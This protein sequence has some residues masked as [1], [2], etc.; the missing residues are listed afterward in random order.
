MMKSFRLLVLAFSVLL[1]WVC[2]VAG[3]T[4]ILNASNPSGAKLTITSPYGELPEYGFLPIVAELTNPGTSKAVWD[5]EQSSYGRGDNFQRHFRLE[6]PPMESRSVALLLATGSVMPNSYYGG[7]NY[8]NISVRS[9]GMG[10]SGNMNSSGSSGSSA[11]GILTGMKHKGNFPPGGWSRVA[12]DVSLASSDWRAYQGFGGVL[13]SDLE[14]RSMNPGQKLALTTWVKNGGALLVAATESGQTAATLG[15]PAND[16]ST[17]ESA[18]GLGYLRVMEAK[19]IAKSASVPFLQH[20]DA[21]R[22]SHQSSGVMD[23]WAAK[24]AMLAERMGRG[25]LTGLMLLVV[26]V[27]AV[28]IGPINLFIIAPAK[29]RHKLFFSVPIISA[30]AGVF[31][32]ASVMISD[33]IG[34]KGVRYVL[35]ENRPGESENNN[36]VIQYQSSQ[37]GVLFTTGF[38]TKG[39]VFVE[40]LAR[41]DR[42]SRDF[43]GNFE[44]AIIPDGLE[45]NGPWFASRTRQHYRLM[46][47]NPSRG[48]IEISGADASTRLTSTFDFPLQTLYF[49]RDGKEWWKATDIQQGVPTQVAAIP[50]DEVQT[51][52][53]DAVREAPRE[54]ADK[55][56]ELRQR[57]MHYIALTSAPPA[58]AT[59]GAIKWTDQGFITG[60]LVVP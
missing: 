2:P 41:T 24:N 33:G 45:A 3:Q 19:E 6:C 31:L 40:R 10:Q 37:C 11:R 42:Y 17:K 15:L 34:G 25:L 57:P 43:S 12:F 39:P 59:H 18:C 7:Y 51:H 16:P 58:I 21:Y 32:L 47:V 55:V 22:G 52:L 53:A 29:R 23:N 14:W 5:V 48:R 44:L 50:Y 46:G 20:E 54:L 56:T 28:V 27:F 49:S 26:A 8:F 30:I 13:M 35:V 9:D 38:E 1:A 4:Q 60:P 36:H